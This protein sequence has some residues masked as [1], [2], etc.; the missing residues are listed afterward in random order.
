MGQRS[1]LSL[2]KASSGGTDWGTF[3][4]ILVEV[5]WM[6]ASAFIIFLLFCFVAA[7]NIISSMFIERVLSLAQPDLEEQ[8][9]KKRRKDMSDTEEMVSIISQADTDR[10]GR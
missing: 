5:G 10:S 9:L 8:M 6:P 1:T 4:S 7:W 2:F 3:Y